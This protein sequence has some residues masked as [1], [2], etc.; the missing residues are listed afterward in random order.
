MANK[1][2]ERKIERH[3]PFL[4]R[5][6]KVSI[7]LRQSMFQAGLLNPE[8]QDA[9]RN[10]PAEVDRVDKL[11]DIMRCKTKKDWE[12]FLQCLTDCGR[13]ELAEYLRKEDQTEPRTA[14][15]CVRPHSV[16]IIKK[17]KV[18]SGLRWQLQQQGILDD[19]DVEHIKKAESFQAKNDI[20]VE[21]MCR[22]PESSW[23]KFKEALVEDRQIQ[24]ASELNGGQSMGA[25]TCQHAEEPQQ[26]TSMFDL[27]QR[28]LEEES[29]IMKKKAA[30]MED[31]LQRIKEGEEPKLTD[32]GWKKIILEEGHITNRDP[33]KTINL[34]TQFIKLRLVLGND[35]LKV[36]DILPGQYQ[37]YLQRASGESIKL[38]DLLTFVK[39]EEKP[40]KVGKKEKSSGTISMRTKEE[41]K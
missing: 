30:T 40:F 26:M 8:H 20:I 21:C 14:L 23:Q 24:L 27:I 35:K 18:R 15:E 32:L 37:N 16:S 25:S 9:L 31:M 11:L 28:L 17:L 12:I 19:E 7:N 36:N 39:Y 5:T 38:E 33:D 29:T 41:T 2:V 13:A 6:L 34:D 1:V 3:R 22:Q 4:L 10:V